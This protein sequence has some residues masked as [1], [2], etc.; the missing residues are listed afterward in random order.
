MFRFRKSVPV[1]YDRQGM[2]Y[3][4]SRLYR[5][6]PE[7]K[8]ARIRCL[9]QDAGGEYAEALFDFM[10]GDLTAPGVCAKYYISQSTLDRVV[11]K[12]YMIFPKNL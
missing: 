6:L 4:Y 3:F 5:T 1:S 10:V 9:C 7:K 12:Y 11:R 8:Q 2:I